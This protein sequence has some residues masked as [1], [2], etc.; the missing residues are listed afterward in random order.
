MSFPQDV[1][2]ACRRIRK[3]RVSTYSEVAKAAGR[4]RAC[5]AVGNILNRNPH[6][7]VPCHRVVR[8]D[9]SLGGFAR[10]PCKK[11]EM[12]AAEGLEIQGGRIA[13]FRKRLQRL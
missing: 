10:G 9:G 12:L 1:Y 11:R 5:R 2:R 8:S 7:S 3:G 13:G 4:P 6:S